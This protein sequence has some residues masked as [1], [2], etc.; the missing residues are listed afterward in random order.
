MN[1]L[2]TR[3]FSAMNNAEDPILDQLDYDLQKAYSEGS[4]NTEEYSIKRSGNN[5]VLFDKIHSE[6]TIATPSG[7][8]F[9]L[10]DGDIVQTPVGK[11]KFISANNN[12]AVIEQGGNLVNHDLTEIKPVSRKFV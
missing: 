4:M 10:K 1:H 3:L 8:S 12:T 6:T 9:T 7:D 2:M 5:L 11:G